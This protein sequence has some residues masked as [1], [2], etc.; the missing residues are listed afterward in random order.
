MDN[1]YF[2]LRIVNNNFIE[3]YYFFRIHNYSGNFA[4]PICFFI[5]TKNFTAIILLFS[6]SIRFSK[7]S[8]ENK[9][10]LG[11]EIF[12]ALITLKLKQRY[13]QD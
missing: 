5:N 1:G 13:V 4:Y 6:L 12:K 11:K 7:S 2:T 9:M 8:T 3:V 10:Y